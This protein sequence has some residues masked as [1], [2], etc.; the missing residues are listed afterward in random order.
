MS[1]YFIREGDLIKIGFSSNVRSRV[2]AIINGLRGKGELLGYM[3]GDRSVEKHFHQM[4]A[5]DREYG[6]WFCVSDKLLTVIET[7][8]TKEPQPDTLKAS[9]R[10]Q[11]QEER[12]AEE[13]AYFIRTF[14]DGITPGADVWP[15][16]EASTS[17]PGDRLRLIY[18]GQVCPITAGEYVV[19]RMMHD[20]ALGMTEE[21]HAAAE[22]EAKEWVQRYVANKR[23]KEAGLTPSYGREGAE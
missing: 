10:L 20:A 12:Y 4:F 11:M 21:D 5:A 9:D 16:L 13:G 1:V 8:T 18:D 22:Q 6:E 3:P 17:I 19:L 23:R 2:M 14:L 15:K 7:M